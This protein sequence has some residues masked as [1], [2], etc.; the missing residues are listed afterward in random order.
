MDGISTTIVLDTRRVK[1]NDVYPVKLRVT[2]ERKQKYYPT[3]YNLSKE[4]YERLMFGKKLSE[5]DK[6]K[7][8]KIND[9]QAKAASIIQEIQVFSWL[10]FENL[11]YT[12]RA[13][14]EF[15]DKAF[16][17]YITY[18]K[19]EERLG[20][21][22]SYECA[23]N[24]LKLYQQELKFRDIT[25]DFLKKY[26]NWML[27]NRK[28]I[29]TVGIYLRPL[30]AIFNKAIT[31]GHLSKEY[32][33][34]GKNRYEIPT[35]K[36]TKKALKINQIGEIF[37]YK[38]EPGSNEEK[39]RDYWLFLYFCN[40]MNVKDMCLLKYK[41]INAETLEFIRAKTVRTKR[42]AEPIRIVLIKEVK[43]IIE[44][45]GNKKKDE[46]S[47]IFPELN[48]GLTKE[49]ER[50]LIQQLTKA[51]NK[52]MKTIADNLEIKYKITTYFARHSF[53]SVL[54]RSGKS[55]EFISEAI[56]H[57]DVKT[58]QLYL[59]GFEDDEKIEAAK[60]LTAF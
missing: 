16:D 51:I 59:A 54:Q 47:Y 36:N 44:K 17:E 32:Y 23:I 53:A 19:E 37:Y 13:A 39:Y 56:G 41:N 55:A 46:D 60:A 42:V 45:W 50:K 2:F 14:K 3:K 49:R 5:K 27:S 30:R 8:N 22:S 43:E 52:K 34:F 1:K 26:E 9:Y 28:S 18:L 35:K 20:T 31:E 4:E 24:S 15:V 40:G 21:A 6:E 12:D 11:Y 29:T 58:T 48:E 57:G 7:K 33:P 38:P 10:R 25:V